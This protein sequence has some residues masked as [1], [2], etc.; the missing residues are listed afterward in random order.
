M[1][2]AAAAAHH[3]ADIDQAVA[4]AVQAWVRRMLSIAQLPP[5][6]AVSVQVC[7]FVCIQ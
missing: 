4:G 2:A 5:A 3:P 7:A 1:F 6:T